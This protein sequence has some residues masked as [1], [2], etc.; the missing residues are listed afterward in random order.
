MYDSKAPYIAR[1]TIAQGWSVSEIFKIILEEK[2]VNKDE[3]TRD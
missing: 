2:K 3:D 1:G